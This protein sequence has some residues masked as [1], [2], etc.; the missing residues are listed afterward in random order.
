VTAHTGKRCRPSWAV[1]RRRFATRA[2][3]R[4]VPRHPVSK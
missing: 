3:A 1:E 4:N 2:A